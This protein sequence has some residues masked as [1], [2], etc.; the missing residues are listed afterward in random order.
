MAFGTNYSAAQ[1]YDLIPQGSYEAV[2]VNAEVKQ[3]PSGKWKVGFSLVIRN[4]VQQ[5]CQNR[6]LFMDIWRKKEPNANDMQ[7]D[8]FNFGQLMGVARAAGI[9]DGQSFE[10][11]GDF[12]RVLVN[13][14]I[15]VTVTHREYNG[16]VSENIDQ[17][18]GLAVT[19][20]PEC[21]HVQK[22]KAQSPAYGSVAP[23]TPA[24]YAPPM[25]HGY[26]RHPKVAPPASAPMNLNPNDFEEILSND[27]V[28]F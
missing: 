3:I 7:V 20:F 4:D 25:Q 12:L 1:Q 11:L 21:R 13:R 5:Q 15:R 16:T 22:Q 19:K 17:L 26:A 10:S 8:G 28:P 6:Y 14:C 18:R 24:Q 23:P 2:I 27:E 9:P